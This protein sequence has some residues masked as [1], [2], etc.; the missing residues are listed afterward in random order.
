MTV[1]KYLLLFLVLLFSHSSFGNELSPIHHPKPSGKGMVCSCNDKQSSLCPSETKGTKGFLFGSEA[2]TLDFI[3][4]DE[5]NEVFD[6]QNFVLNREVSAKYGVYEDEIVWYWS[7]HDLKIHELY[8]YLFSLNRKTL[9]LEFKFQTIPNGGNPISEKKSFQ[10]RVYGTHIET[11]LQL[12]NEKQVL[13]NL[14]DE[15]TSGN[16]I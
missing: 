13:Q 1:M 2:V 12:E 11:I 9:D 15:K 8:T 5:Q 3:S 6:I 16:K 4:F 10:C 14:Y 7:G